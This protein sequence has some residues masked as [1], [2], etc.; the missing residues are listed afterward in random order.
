MIEGAAWVDQVF[1]VEDPSAVIALVPACVWVVAVG[2][3]SFD[4]TVWEKALVIE[5]VELGYLLAV[6]EA[7]LLNFEVE[8]SDEL[9]VDWAFGSG[10]I[11]EF[12]LERLQ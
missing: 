7:V 1:R 10:I 9:F 3:F 2:T 11:V 4:E 12:Y 6:N 5:A 8:V